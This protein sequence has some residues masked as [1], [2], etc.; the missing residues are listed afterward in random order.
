[1]KKV[2]IW[3]GIIIS[4]L[5]LVVLTV[6]IVANEPLPSGVPGPEAEV[7]AQK[8]LAAVDKEAWD[9]T[10]FVTWN[11]AGIHDYLWDKDRHAVQVRWSDKEVL[12]HT[13]SVTGLAFETG[14]PVSGER[15]KKL[16]DKAW[17]FFCNDSFWLNAVV[18][19]YDPGTTRSLVRTD[20]GGTALLV[21]YSSGGV[22][23]GDS[24]L[25]F[26]D[27][28]GT[29]RKWKMWVS[30][31]PIGGVS[32]TWEDWVTLPTGAKVATAHRGGAFSLLL[33][34]VHGG[35]SLAALGLTEDPFAALCSTERCW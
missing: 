3:V 24:Y 2:L 22:T 7:L 10:T 21:S 33:Q 17:A 14:K 26:L 28:D 8:M 13:K 25:W 9:T 35:T 34:E 5:I 19:A 1:M 29:P 27:A 6:A 12:L 31:I 23:P 4:A 11:F 32:V 18:K 16:V 20:D 30:V 15:A